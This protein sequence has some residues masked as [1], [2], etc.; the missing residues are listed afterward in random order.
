MNDLT[1]FDS[2]HNFNVGINNIYQTR[3]PK[4]VKCSKLNMLNAE[5]TQYIEVP[6]MELFGVLEVCSAISVASE[7]VFPIAGN[8]ISSQRACLLP[9]N[10]C[11][12]YFK[13]YIDKY[14]YVFSILRFMIK[15]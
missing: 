5:F 10:D 1:L 15:T 13:I 12:W 2:L 3:K 6:C 9:D 11:L 8:I 7:V 14:V 4:S